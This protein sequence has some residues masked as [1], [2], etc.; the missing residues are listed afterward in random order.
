MMVALGLGVRC[1]IPWVRRHYI[2]EA[3]HPSVPENLRVAMYFRI[4]QS[5]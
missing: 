5:R 3:P 2:R 4:C 1:V